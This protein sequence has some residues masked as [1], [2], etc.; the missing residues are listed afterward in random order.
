MS[1]REILG[2]IGNHRELYRAAESYGGAYRA[3]ESCRELYRATYI[4]L[5]REQLYGSYREL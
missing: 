1:Y 2:A 3:I 5:Y 4:K